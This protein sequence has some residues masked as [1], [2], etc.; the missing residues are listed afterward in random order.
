MRHRQ[1]AGG[2]L[3][4]APGTQPSN[5]SGATFAIVAGPSARR[6]VLS[7]S[8]GERPYD[9]QGTRF[10]TSRLGDALASPVRDALRPDFSDSAF[11]LRPPSNI[12]LASRRGGS[13]LHESAGVPQNRPR[14]QT[15]GQR[16]T[17]PSSGL[18]RTK[19]LERAGHEKKPMTSPAQMLFS[20]Q[21]HI[22]RAVLARLVCS[23][24]R[25]IAPPAWRRCVI[26]RLTLARGSVAY[27]TTS[28]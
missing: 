6:F 23:W 9:R 7:L 17:V 21:G 2:K 16:N 19:P 4:E 18:G 27:Q 13:S 11:T 8:S 22:F 3:G 14:P 24:R 10:V 1:T 20:Y 26:A 28:R 5:S 25:F 15:C 12:G